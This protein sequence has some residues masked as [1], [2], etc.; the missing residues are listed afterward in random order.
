VILNAELYNDALELVNT[1][2]VKLDLKSDSGKNFSFLFTR[3]GQGYQLDAGA[4]LSGDY[5]YTASTRSGNQN[6]TANG[7]LTVK[8]LNLETRQTAADHQLLRALAKQSGGQF[9]L[10]SQVDQLADL[11]RKNDN[12]KTLVY[13]DKHYSDLVDLKWIF[14]LIV[15]MLGFEWFMRKREGEL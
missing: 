10:P 6:L 14:V 11:I 7:R 9:L 4:L 5:S 13:E 15:S 2:D 1:P 12:I 3:T 8:P